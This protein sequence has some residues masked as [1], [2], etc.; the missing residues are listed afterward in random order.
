MIYFFII[1]TILLATGLV[2]TLFTLDSK[3]K[4]QK[5]KLNLLSNQYN[6]LRKTTITEK[7]LF[8]N[9][10]IQ[11]TKS[12]YN[13]G[14]TTE[15]VK[16]NYLPLEGFKTVIE[17][18]SPL[19]LYILEQCINSTEVWFYVDLKM[20]NNINSRGWIKKSDF[21]ILRDDYNPVKSNLLN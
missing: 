17:I 21:S 12:P 10:N 9:L 7:S 19:E 3:L 18:K 2:L 16:V 15:N 5:K 11:Y 13:Y 1:L 6:N 8:K 4:N 14:I 20:Q